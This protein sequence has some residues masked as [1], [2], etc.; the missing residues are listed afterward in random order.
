MLQREVLKIQ[1]SVTGEAQNR[2][3]L[4]EKSVREEFSEL[5][6]EVK[7]SAVNLQAGL[8]TLERQHSNLQ[9][10]VWAANGQY[11]NAFSAYIRS[12]DI[13]RK[14]KMEFGFTNAIQ[15]LEKLVRKMDG[16]FGT[17]VAKISRFLDSIENQE[18]TQVRRLRDLLNG[19]KVL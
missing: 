2:L 18:S 4:F 1:E 11:G 15:E 5:H 12:A 17:D 10:E 3:S 8:L 7:S 19:V 13:S 6:D 16:V 9:A 14:L